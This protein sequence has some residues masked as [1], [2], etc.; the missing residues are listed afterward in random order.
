MDVKP[1]RPPPFPPPLQPDPEP[2]RDEDDAYG[3]RPP[4]S[5]G[6]V[7]ALGILNIV[8]ALVCG[9]SLGSAS[10]VLSEISERDG[11]VAFGSDWDQQMEAFYEEMLNDADSQMERDDLELQLDFMKSEEV[12]DA[13]REASSILS[14]SEMGTRLQQASTA[15]L[16]IQ[17]LML[18]SGVLLL[19]RIRI[20]RPLALSATFLTI[21][22]QIALLVFML[23]VVDELELTFGER[24]DQAAAGNAQH[25]GPA[26]R[27]RMEEDVTG[28]VGEALRE[29]VVGATGVAILYPLIAFLVLLFSRSIR[30]ILDEGRVASRP[31]VF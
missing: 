25:F 22:V 17:L 6:S 15:G 8:F 20:A 31:D 1:P 12:K 4:P 16:V 10:A 7:V 30:S 11:G 18:L 27:E 24:I 5:S 9:C 29:L 3:P 28:R 14:T 2:W 26:A 13:L 23:G 21:L 19:A